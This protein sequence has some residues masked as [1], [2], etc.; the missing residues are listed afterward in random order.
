MK[1]SSTVI[2]AAK[3]EATDAAPG[4]GRA[5]RVAARHEVASRCRAVA[6]GKN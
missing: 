5:M 3:P 2:T 1:K 6:F 4:G